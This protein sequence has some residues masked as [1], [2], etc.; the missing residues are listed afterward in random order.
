MQVSLR[1]GVLSGTMTAGAQ[2]ATLLEM[3]KI[4]GLFEFVNHHLVV[5]FRV[6]TEVTVLITCR[7]HSKL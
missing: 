3:C 4:Q 7:Q 2:D 1:D 5:L 6:G